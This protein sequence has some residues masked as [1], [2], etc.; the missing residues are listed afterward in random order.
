VAGL[1]TP[2]EGAVKLCKD[3]R[4]YSNQYPDWGSPRFWAECQHSTAGRT[5][6]PDLVS[7][8]FPQVRQRTCEEMRTDSRACGQ[9]GKLFEPRDD[10]PQTIP[11]RGFE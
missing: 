7:G 3:C 11:D 2:E 9:D 8:A 10:E 4:F 1:A 5:S 6:A